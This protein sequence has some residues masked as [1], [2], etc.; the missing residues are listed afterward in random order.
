MDNTGLVPLTRAAKLN[1][2]TVNRPGIPF[3]DQLL[4]PNSPQNTSGN[5]TIAF[6]LP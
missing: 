3:E 2:A 6:L 1:A 4:T 5:S